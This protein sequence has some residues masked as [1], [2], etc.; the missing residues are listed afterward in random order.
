VRTAGPRDMNPRTV[1]AIAAKRRGFLKKLSGFAPSEAGGPEI[2]PLDYTA[3]DLYLYVTSRA[4]KKSRA[5][6]CSKEPWTVAW[7]ERVVRPGHIVYDIGANVGAYA[8]VAAQHAGP[9]GQV[10]AFEPGYA[11]FAHLCDNIILNGCEAVITPLSFPLSSSTGLMRFGYHKLYPGHARHRGLAAGSVSGSDEPAYEQPVPA[12]R[13]DD[14]VRTFALPL[15]DHVKVDV[16][17][18]EQTVLD[19]A[20]ATC[21]HRGL[22]SV[23]VEIDDRNTAGVTDLM[24]RAGLRLANRYERTEDGERLP[25]WYGVFERVL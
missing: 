22:K 6:S 1:D 17:G 12:M 18:A 21:A 5:L 7:I 15:P 4:E 25:F 3:A 24:D 9:G 16:D 11:T 10:F 19:G 20:R 2:L 23:L 13:L 14:A 8:L